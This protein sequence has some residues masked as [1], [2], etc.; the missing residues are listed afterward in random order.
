MR[1]HSFELLVGTG[2][3]Y[4]L[5][6]LMTDPAFQHSVKWAEKYASPQQ[7]CCKQPE[8]A[9]A[10]PLFLSTLFLWTV[11]PSAPTSRPISK[12]WGIS[13]AGPHILCHY[14]VFQWYTCPSFCPSFGLVQYFLLY[15]R[16][17][18]PGTCVA[19]PMHR[20]AAQPSSRRIM[21]RS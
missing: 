10:R 1:R 19:N 13:C 9:Y 4:P 11:R 2:Q 16:K 14:H 21:S 5:R 8:T 18:R 3:A 17:T 12:C 7:D 6:S 15:P 20:W